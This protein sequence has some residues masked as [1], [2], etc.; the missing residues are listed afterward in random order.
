MP[1]MDAQQAP[2][3]LAVFEGRGM[4]KPVAATNKGFE[5]SETR[6][7]Q[8]GERG[9][10]GQIGKKARRER[11]HRRSEMGLSFELHS[12]K[13]AWMIPNDNMILVSNYM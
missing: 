13:Y 3:V 4:M 2:S 7:E 8:Q 12:T 11:G 9:S 10:L 1:D 6:T 5:G